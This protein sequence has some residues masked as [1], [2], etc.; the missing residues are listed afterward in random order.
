MKIDPKLWHWAQGFDYII[1]PLRATF[2]RSGHAVLITKRD[3][4]DRPYIWHVQTFY[5]PNGQVTRAQAV[6]Y[7]NSF[8]RGKGVVFGPRDLA[9]PLRMDKAGLPPLQHDIVPPLGWEEL[10]QPQAKRK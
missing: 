4:W 2:S 5:G 1:R 7:G 10:S 3:A 8:K 9:L 6:R